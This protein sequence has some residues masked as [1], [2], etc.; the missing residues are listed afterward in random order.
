MHVTDDIQR[1]VAR[2]WAEVDARLDRLQRRSR[3]VGDLPLYRLDEGAPATA[4]ELDELGKAL[5]VA[6]PPELAYSLMRWNGRWIAHDHI[7][8]LSPIADHLRTEAIERRRRARSS[9][10]D[11]RELEASTF[12]QVLGPINP[13]AESR[14]RIAFGGHEYSGSALYLDYEDPPPGGTLGQ[15]IR[16]GEEP[17]AEFVAPSFVDFLLRVAQ[18]PVHDDDPAH[19]PLAWGGA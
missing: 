3:E 7:I 12:E 14:R 17:V 1:A 19:D 8:S 9:E 2:A 16:I 18:A 6:V 13:K 11:I 10:R 4:G 5:E 15:V